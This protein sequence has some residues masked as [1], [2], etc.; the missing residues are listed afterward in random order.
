MKVAEKSARSTLKELPFFNYRGNLIQIHGQF[1]NSLSTFCTTKRD[2]EKLTCLYDLDLFTLNTFLDCNLNP[3]SQSIVRIPSRYY[4][5]HSFRQMKTK[6]SKAEIDTSF[7]VF[8]NNVVSLNRNLENLQT[9]ILHELDFHF[10]I[11]GV[12][13]TKI[14]NANSELCT[15]KIPGYSFEYAPTPLSSGGVGLF[16]DESLNYRILEK[17]SN[18]AFQALWAEITFENKKTV[19]CGIFHRQHNSPERFQLY[20]DESIEKF[21]SSGK[22]IVIMGDFNID[23]LKCGSSNYSL[24]FLSSLQSC[25][26]TPAIDKPTRVRS[27][28]ATLIDDIFI[29]NPDKVMACGNLISDL[30]DHFSQFCILKSMKVKTRVKKSKMRDFSRFSSDRL[31]AD[32]SNVDWDAL[33]ANEPSDVNSVFSSFYNKFNKLIN[34]HAPMKTISNRK[35]KQFS[36]PWITKGLRKSIRVKNKLYVSGDRVK[37]KMYRNKIC[38][39]TRISK[40]QYYTKFFNENL[41]NMKKTWQ[42]INSILAR[43]S[44]NSKPISFIKDPDNDNLISSNPNRIANILNKHFASVGPKLANKLPSVQRNYFDFLNR[45]NSPDTSFAFNLVTETEVKLEISR[46]PNNK[47]HGLYSCPTQILKC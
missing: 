2:L 3:D 37:Y 38:T 24:N 13:E 30:S 12:S 15:A 8:H 31:N 17:I 39:L 11:I 1:N 9:H 25:Y 26:L 18:E 19:I 23:L 47:S 42:G 4:S 16:I 32:L 6:L 27:T 20:F 5:P 33:F 41:T 36:K 21:S 43:K 35:A 7:S 45:S 34:K 28:S 10:N 14:T 22:D 46:I 44:N 29:N 40:Q